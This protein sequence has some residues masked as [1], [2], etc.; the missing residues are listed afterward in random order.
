MYATDGQT[1]GQTNGRTKATLIVPFPTVGAYNNNIVEY[2][3]YM[4]SVDVNKWPF[5]QRFF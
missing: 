1:D 4:S 5:S 2:K 3:Q